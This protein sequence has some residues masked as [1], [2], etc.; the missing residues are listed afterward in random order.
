M[1]HMTLSIKIICDK[2]VWYYNKK[3]SPVPTTIQL[4]IIILPL[5]LK[6]PDPLTGVTLSWNFGSYSSIVFLIVWRQI[7]IPIY[8][9]YSLAYVW[10]VYKLNHNTYMMW[11]DIFA[12]YTSSKS[13]ILIGVLWLNYLRIL[14]YYINIL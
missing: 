12:H 13:S 8:I 3:G 14:F 4:K 2:C 9:F 5:S 1:R 11:F 10:I 7:Y 6:S